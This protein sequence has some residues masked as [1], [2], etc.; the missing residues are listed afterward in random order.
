M[1]L[2]NCFVLCCHVLTAKKWRQSAQRARVS[3]FLV[4][5]VPLIGFIGRLDYQKGA[6]L[7]LGAA[8]WLLNQ[9]VQIVCLG[10]GDKHLEVGSPT[11]HCANA[12]SCCMLTWIG[13]LCVL[14]QLACCSL[15]DAK[16]VIWCSLRVMQRVHF[17]N[18]RTHH[19]Q[20]QLQ[21][22]VACQADVCTAQTSQLI[23]TACG[24]SGTM[25]C[26]PGPAHPM[27]SQHLRCSCHLCQM[28]CNKV[29]FE[30]SC[31]NPFKKR[32]SE[33]LCQTS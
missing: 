32:R 5:Q 4:M 31:E 22:C 1:F 29:W 26:M 24:Q 19:T 13:L 17:V 7:V 16:Q 12:P 20:L 27:Q 28:L 25:S 3:C 9:D 10:T 23:L 21:Q 33:H 11:D 6:D 14:L 2:H 15:H 18:C 8:H 30:H